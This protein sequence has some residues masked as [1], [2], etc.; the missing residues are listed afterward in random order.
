MWF[1]EVFKEDTYMKK[2]LAFVLATLMLVAAFA[3]CNANKKEPTYGTY[4][5]YVNASV[6][7]LNPHVNVDAATVIRPLTTALYRDYLNEAGDGYQ[8]RMH[9]GC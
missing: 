8:A 3:G 7:T 6:T 1:A 9:A 2:Y 4:R 5:D